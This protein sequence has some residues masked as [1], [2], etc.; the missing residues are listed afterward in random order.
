MYPIN[1]YALTRIKDTKL[2]QKLE[3]QMSKR[4]R[5]LYVKDWEMEGL[6]GLTNHLLEVLPAFCHQ[7]MYYSFLI[8]RIGK[9]FDLL[10]LSDDYVLNIELK[11]GNVSREAIKKQLLQN[12]YYL[13]SLGRTVKSYTYVSEDDMLYRLT[14]GDNLV[15]VGWE[16][17]AEDL[18]KLKDCYDGDIETLFN[19]SEFLISPLTDSEKFLNG[20]YFLTFQQRDIKH[21]II[22]NIKAGTGRLQGFTGLPGTGKTLLLYDIAMQLT[23]KQRVAVLHF[24]FF[25]EALQKLNERLKRVDFYACRGMVSLPVLNGYSAILIDEGHHIDGELLED[26]LA[27][28]KAQNIPLVFTFDQE[29][30]IVSEENTSVLGKRLGEEKE[31]IRYTLTNRIRMNKELST[32]INSILNPT[33]YGNRRFYPAVEVTFAG[34]EIEKKNLVEDFEE[35]GFEYIEDATDTSFKEYDKV[36]MVIDERFYYDEAYNLRAKEAESERFSVRNL[37][38]GLS[39][40]RSKIGLV[41]DQNEQVFGEILEILQQ[42]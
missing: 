8:P 20:E 30:A 12:Q 34:S 32:F 18:Q 13:L 35:R 2:L 3:R 33:K 19:E 41:I 27:Y 26:L 40:A 31:F 42:G 6:R 1:I 7:K 39:R 28:S 29:D 16:K 17:L 10:C 4:S 22:E 9:E 23:I 25:P 21:D 5:F 15:Q 14:K 11:S 24:G 38:H 37:Y 36:V